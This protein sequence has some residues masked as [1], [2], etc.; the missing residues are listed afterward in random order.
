MQTFEKLY[1]Q[2]RDAFAANDPSTESL[3]VKLGVLINQYY[4]SDSHY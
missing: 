2:W 4:F 1:K 3:A